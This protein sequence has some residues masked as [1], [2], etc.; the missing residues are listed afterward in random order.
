MEIGDSVFFPNKK[1]HLINVPKGEQFIRRN[2]DG[3]C[4]VWRVK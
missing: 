4:R 1:G 2:I 3:G